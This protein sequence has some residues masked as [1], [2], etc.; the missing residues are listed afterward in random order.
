M[1]N[2]WYMKDSE[3]IPI[4]PFERRLIDIN[5]KI[6]TVALKHTVWLKKN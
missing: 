1:S 5:P 2:I 6:L 4:Y 3:L